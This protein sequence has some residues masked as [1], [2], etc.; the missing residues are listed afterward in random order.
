[1]RLCKSYGPNYLLIARLARLK[2]FR[3]PAGFSLG[4]HKNL[5]LG[6]LPNLFSCQTSSPDGRWLLAVGCGPRTLEPSAFP[7]RLGG[8]EAQMF[9]SFLANSQR[10]VAIGHPRT[11]F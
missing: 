7:A 1:M 4:T 6:S 11:M 9:Q 8:Q 10:P 5:Q 3:T 2:C